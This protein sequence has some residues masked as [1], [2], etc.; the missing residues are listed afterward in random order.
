MSEP[1]LHPVPPLPDDLPPGSGDYEYRLV[2]ISRSTAR[3]HAQRLLTELAER[4][5]WE[6]ALVRLYLGGARR[7]WLRRRIIRVVRTA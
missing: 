1:T 5:H 6:V 7:V 3:S 4:D 2:T